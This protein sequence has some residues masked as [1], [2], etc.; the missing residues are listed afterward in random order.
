[1]IGFRIQGLGIENRIQWER[2]QGRMKQEAVSKK[3]ILQTTKKCPNP[4][5]GYEIQ[6]NARCD[7]VT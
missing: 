4:E 6:K 5:C 3:L 7:Y 1:M 2:R